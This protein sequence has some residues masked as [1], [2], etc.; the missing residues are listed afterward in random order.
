[1]YLR[2]TDDISSGFR[3]IYLFI[4]LCFMLLEGELFGKKWDVRM[5]SG[6]LVE[7]GIDF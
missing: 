1:M 7:I 6:F 3:C 5:C 2:I 4:V